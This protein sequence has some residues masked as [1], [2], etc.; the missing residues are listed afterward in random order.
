MRHTHSFFL[1]L[2]VLAF[3]L[4]TQSTF[5]VTQGEQAM[6][7]QF[8]RPVEQ[9]PEPGLKFK[10]P[11]I[12]Q[13]KFFPTKILGVDPPPEEVILSDQKRLVVDTFARFRITNMLAFNNSF[14]NVDTAT[15][16]LDNIIN[17]VTR[18]VLGTVPLR[19]E[20]K[21]D[22]GIL[23]TQRSD[24]MRKIRDRASD[25]V[26]ENGIQVV[27]VR[28]GRADLPAQTSQSIYARMQSARQLEAAT[29]RAEGK[30]SATETKANAD[31]QQNII[32]A[33]AEKQAQILR[34]EGDAEASKIYANAFKQ[35][36]EFYSFYRTMQAYR[37]SLPGENTTL[38]L[39]PDG[40]F[41]RYFKDE[42]GQ[43]APGKK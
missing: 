27:D 19:V 12:Q 13:V 25:A 24:I 39:T 8:G 1:F 11:F 9:Y 28:I 42:Q 6:V 18:E 15:D 29:Y 43:A 3:V 5:I 32:M 14:G 20:G 10:T 30:Q 40:D 21:E 23:S 31:R 35:D 16:R 38:V 36:P 33:D 37:E 34:G 4:V 2:L 17:S 41:F 7:L 26:K 22:V